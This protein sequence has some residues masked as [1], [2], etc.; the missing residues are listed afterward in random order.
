MAGNRR[1]GFSD[2]EMAE[3]WRGWK[4]GKTLNSIGRALGRAGPHVRSLFAASGGFVPPPRRRSVRVLS[5][6]E[7][8]RIS[9]GVAAGDSMRTIATAL[10]RAPSTVSREIAPERGEYAPF[11]VWLSSYYLSEVAKSRLLFPTRAGLPA[12]SVP[13][14]CVIPRLLALLMLV[15]P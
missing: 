14:G 13:M 10:K 8:E 15:W 3:I 5:G 2:F 7:R 4:S 12:L 11:G 9:R 6:V 1:P